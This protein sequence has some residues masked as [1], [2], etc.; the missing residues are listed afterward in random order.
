MAAL[1][2]LRNDSG[3]PQI[4][5]LR[6]ASIR[7]VPRGTVVVDTKSYVMK[8]RGMTQVA[9]LGDPEPKPD[10]GPSVE[11]LLAT[12]ARLQARLNDGGEAPYPRHQGGGK[13]LLSNG[14]ITRGQLS[15]EAAQTLEDE[16]SES[17]G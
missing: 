12:I 1:I 9:T 10:E 16:L 7:V 17:E 14:E 2:R 3:I 6:G 13:W 8:A 15:R 4:F 11:E 5:N